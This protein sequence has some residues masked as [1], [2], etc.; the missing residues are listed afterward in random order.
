MDG[1]DIDIGASQAHARPHWL[2]PL[3]GV[4]GIPSYWGFSPGWDSSI[5]NRKVTSDLGLDFPILEDV[6]LEL[7]KARVRVRAESRLKEP[8]KVLGA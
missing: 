8:Q 6:A 4:F 5:E 3:L 1:A 7:S 2:A